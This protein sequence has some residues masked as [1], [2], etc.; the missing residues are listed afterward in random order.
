LKDW[1]SQDGLVKKRM[2]RFAT[3]EDLIEYFLAVASKKEK[4]LIIDWFKNVET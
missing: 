2:G 3:S 4:E 1:N